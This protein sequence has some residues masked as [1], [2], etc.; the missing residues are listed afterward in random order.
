MSERTLE[1]RRFDALWGSNILW[2][3][4]LLLMVAGLG[5]IAWLAGLVGGFCLGYRYGLRERTNDDAE[6]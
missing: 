4:G 6:A 1:E 2:A 5:S 3:T